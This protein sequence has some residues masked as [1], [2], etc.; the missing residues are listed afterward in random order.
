MFHIMASHI[1]SGF[2]CNV[3]G[4]LSNNSSIYPKD[5]LKI[6]KGG[7]RNDEKVKENA[8]NKKYCGL[9]L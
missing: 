4:N 5:K 1:L 7:K 6:I 8:I 3:T 2:S 9:F